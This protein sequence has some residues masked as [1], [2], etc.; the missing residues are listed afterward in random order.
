MTVP[1]YDGTK[2]QLKVPDE[3]RNIPDI[4]PR[5]LGHIPD[6]SLALVTYTVSMYSATSGQRK[7]QVTT[8]LHIHFAVVLHN[9]EFESIDEAD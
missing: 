3:L 9:P 2:R 6:Y 7:D 4:L 5:Y 8:P 1:I